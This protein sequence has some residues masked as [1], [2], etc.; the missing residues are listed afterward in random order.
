MQHRLQYPEKS[1]SP[2]M[3]KTRYFQTNINSNNIYPQIQPYRKYQKENC[4][5]GRITTRKEVILY[6]KNQECAPTHSTI[7]TTSTTKNIKIT[8]NNNHW[9]LISLNI[10][11]FNSQIM[12]LNESSAKKKVHKEFRKF[13]HQKFKST[14]ESSR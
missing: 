7:T 11:G 5:P 2:Q 1:K 9:L 13:S 10:T 6:Q 14:L 12:G 8:G 3:K 4:N